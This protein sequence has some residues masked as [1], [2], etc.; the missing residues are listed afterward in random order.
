MFFADCRGAYT[1]FFLCDPQHDAWNGNNIK[2][3]VEDNLEQCLYEKKQSEVQLKGLR[4]VQFQMSW[5]LQ[6]AG[7]AGSTSHDAGSCLIN[8]HQQTWS[9]LWSS[10][11]FQ[12]SASVST[13]ITS[14]CCA[15]FI[16][17]AISLLVLS[18]SLRA[19]W[20]KY[21]SDSSIGRNMKPETA[22]VSRE[23]E[24]YQHCAAPLIPAELSRFIQGVM[25]PSAV[26][27]CVCMRERESE[28]HAAWIKRLVKYRQEEEEKMDSGQERRMKE[29]ESSK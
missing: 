10:E 22:E 20:Q 16:V 29:K 13:H 26:C 25:C 5:S 27:M 7:G 23:R 1:I 2:K 21:S 14:N 8:W 12:A 6:P 18:L 4:C 11:V 28:S 17:F 15:C 24:C 9:R 19:F 3:A